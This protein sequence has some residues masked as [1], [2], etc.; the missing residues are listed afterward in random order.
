MKKYSFFNL[1]HYKNVENP[2]NTYK[3]AY[4]HGKITQIPL[5]M[6]F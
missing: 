3:N 4:F 1:N 5:I 6:N 2:V